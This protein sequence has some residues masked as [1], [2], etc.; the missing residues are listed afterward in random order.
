MRHPSRRWIG[1]LLAVLLAAILPDGQGARAQ[2]ER[3]L[4]SAP[5]AGE[6]RGVG[7]LNVYGSRFCTA[8]LIDASHVL[9]AA[10]CLY[11]PITKRLVRLHGLTFVAGQYRDEYA[12]ARRVV[13]MATL[14]GFDFTAAANLGDVSRD[15]ALLELDRPIPRSAAGPLP[16]AASGGERGGII[17]S[18]ARDRAYAPSIAGPCA[19]R[20]V[21]GAGVAMLACGVNAG[22]SG[23]PVLA[24]R[25]GARRVVAVVSAMARDTRGSDVALT[26]VA[27]PRIAALRAAL[28]ARPVMSVAEQDAERDRRRRAK[29]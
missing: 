20:G 13:R 18:Y 19:P 12:A 27:P 15:M 4:L 29:D 25:P 16:V 6:F 10:H 11:S 23:A 5:E 24:G 8:T 2:T 7:R 9:T 17:V 3:R 22:V 21:T 26:V 28:S 1:L 14:P